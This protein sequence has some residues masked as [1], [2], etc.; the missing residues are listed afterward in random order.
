MKQVN[1]YVTDEEYTLLV[2]EAGR[3]MQETGKHMPLGRLAGLLVSPEIAK[4]NGSP[5][6]A[7]PNE[8]SKQD[9]KQDNEQETNPFANLDI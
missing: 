8:D 4:L 5:P 7:V 6:T 2:K 9:D 3:I 1:V